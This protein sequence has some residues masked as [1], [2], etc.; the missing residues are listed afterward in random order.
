[1]SSQPFSGYADFNWSQGE[2]SAYYIGDGVVITAGHALWTIDPKEDLSKRILKKNANSTSLI[3]NREYF[4]H[5]DGLMRD[6]RARKDGESLSDYQAEMLGLAAAFSVRARDTV[7]ADIAGNKNVDSDSAGLVLFLGGSADITSNEFGLSNS[8]NDV[9][10]SWEGVRTNRHHDGSLELLNGFLSYATQS[11]PN[12]AYGGPGDSGAGIVVNFTNNAL[13]MGD[14]HF[15]LGNVHSVVDIPSA[16]VGSQ[17]NDRRGP[18]MANW[19]KSADFTA[20]MA[21]LENAQSKDVTLDEPTNLIVG[22]VN[23]EDAD[24]SY[25]ADIILGRGGDDTIRDGDE[26]GDLVWANDQLFGG[27]DD[28]VF[29]AGAGND[30]IHGGDFRS[31]GAEGNG[32]SPRIALDEDGN[33]T[34]DYNAIDQRSPTADA[35]LVVQIGLQATQADPQWD[36]GT[37][38]DATDRSA[39]IYVA[40]LDAAEGNLG[41]DALVS[42]EKV[43]TTGADDVLEIH[44]LNGAYLAGEDTLGGVFLVDLGANDTTSGKGDKVQFKGVTE[45]F[46]VDLREPQDGAAPT[47]NVHATSDPSRGLNV[48]NAEIFQGGESHMTVFSKGNGEFHAGS[49]GATFHLQPGDVAIGY[50]GVVDN[51]YVSTIPP[52]EMSPEEAV[53]WLKQ[54]KVLLDFGA[55][56]FVFV[57][58]IKYTGNQISAEFGESAAYDSNHDFRTSPV[59][60]TGDSSYGTQ[61][62]TPEFELTAVNHRGPYGHLVVADQRIRHTG[63]ERADENGAGFI[64]FWSRSASGVSSEFGGYQLDALSHDDEMLT[65]VVMNFSN[66]DAGISFGTDG[67]AHAFKPMETP[68][69]GAGGPVGVGTSGREATKESF[70]TEY[71]DENGN[72]IEVRGDEEFS[73]DDPRYFAFEPRYADQEINWRDW[74]AASKTINGTDGHDELRGGGSSD[75]LFGGSGDDLLIGGDGDDVLFGGVGDDY[76]IGKQGND[77]LDGGVGFD[78]AGFDGNRDDYTIFFD[79]TGKVIVEVALEDDSFFPIP[80]DPI[81]GGPGEPIGIMSQSSS[82]QS[83][84]MDEFFLPREHDTLTAIEMLSFAD[85]D[86]AISSIEKGTNEADTF[87][88]IAASSV[89]YGLGGNDVIS[90][91]SGEN[92][93]FGGAGDDQLIGGLGD[94]HLD[95]GADVDTMSGG[96]GDDTYVVDSINDVVVE[97]EYD[98]NDT[99]Q[100]TLSTFTLGENLEN[101]IYVG[102]GDFVGT[103]NEDHNVLAGGEGDDQLFG[104]DGDDLFLASNGVDIIDGGE[105]F[106]IL[107]LT[108]QKSDYQVVELS[109]GAFN[110]LGDNVE[111]TVNDIEIIQFDDFGFG[112]NPHQLV[113]SAIYGTEGSDSLSGTSD[114]DVIYGKGGD[115]VFQTSRGTDVM[116]GGAGV[117]TVSYTGSSTDFVVYRHPADVV[118]VNDYWGIN[119]TGFDNLKNVEYVEFLGDGV[120]IAIDDLPAVGTSGDDSLVGSTNSDWLYGLDGDDILAGGGGEQDRLEGG[121]GNDLYL[122]SE[123]YY[124]TRDDS[125]DDTYN[126]GG[127]GGTIYDWDGNDTYIFEDFTNFLDQG[128][129]FEIT[130]TGGFNRILFGANIA[131]GDVFVHAGDDDIS[132]SIQGFDGNLVI[133]DGLEEGSGIAEMHFDD[134]TIWNVFDRLMIASEDDDNL[135]GSVSDDEIYG[136]GGDDFI[137]GRGGDDVLAG[138]QGA[139]MLYGGSGSDT[140]LFNLGDGIDRI[141]DQSVSGSDTDSIDKLIF[142]TGILATEISAV[143]QYSDLRLSLGN[144]GDMVI[145][146]KYFVSESDHIEEVQFA[147]GTNWVLADIMAMVLNP[148]LTDDVLEGSFSDDILSGLQGNDELNGND[149]DDILIGGLG[150]D[151]L[152]GGAG[153]DVFL[154]NLG[155]GHDVIYDVDYSYEGTDVVEFG[156][157]V[158]PSDVSVSFANNERDFFL[159]INGGTGSITLRNAAAYS[160]NEIEEVRFA[161]GET[162]TFDDL[163]ALA[164]GSALSST[165]FS[166]EPFA[167]KNLFEESPNTLLSVFHRPTL[168]GLNSKESTRIDGLGF[169]A[170]NSLSARSSDDV[171]LKDWLDIGPSMH[172]VYDPGH[173]S[174]AP[175]FSGSDAAKKVAI[176]RQDMNAFGVQNGIGS[177]AMGRALTEYIEFYA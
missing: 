68:F 157:G 24:G 72:I 158:A 17:P 161:N 128:G 117:D 127:Y 70:V 105:G 100:T 16:A 118:I 141:R 42:I 151:T 62:V 36:K 170:R 8:S 45:N 22:T 5:L 37:Y 19:I 176:I 153:D 154:F 160:A 39:A 150:N 120:T 126:L 177:S 89:F 147:D 44:A 166:S 95:G 58:G 80:G 50:E 85:I 86:L 173:A 82:S 1:M 11:N 30:L 167:E 4:N 93:F 2:A 9:K 7:Y 129:D 74:V 98:G 46:T 10:V 23:G 104:L 133:I 143:R 138:G 162:W 18:I 135:V 90:G 35:G 55:E 99:I 61:Y 146:E 65:I 79:E 112:Y 87:A 47:F 115:D 28:D 53:E 20:V 101:L 91:T 77:V 108:G 111:I 163:Y 67:L 156:A 43:V 168:S 75:T 149:G 69:E 66:G 27:A 52:V 121:A 31:Y 107:A 73:I 144:S 125:G 34:I 165:E 94:D 12:D 76:L 83:L 169:A 41:T 14:R 130:D 140:Y 148:S 26:A 33:D 134:G 175:S 97:F 21:H 137:S 3:D 106:D 110:I 40:D 159:S 71:W 145:L 152:N 59:F 29:Y 49:G 132:V 48:E 102:T 119:R 13:A 114:D 96:Y 103:G 136:L 38:G 109:T 131:P 15:V 155:D 56:D 84:G 64:N 122:L 63:Y 25:R 139:D 32:T 142:G 60:V 116:D 164:E 172:G 123:S 51:F 54:N 88:G 113:S 57:N 92:R 6:F 81:P 78:I 124:V 171:D 174:I